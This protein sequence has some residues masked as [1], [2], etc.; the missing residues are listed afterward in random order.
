LEYLFL[1][2]LNNFPDNQESFS[3]VSNTVL[4]QKDRADRLREL[5]AQ[6]SEAELREDDTAVQLA[7]AEFQEIESQMVEEFHRMAY[8]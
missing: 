8:Y 2:F 1:T 5:Q 7:R 4:L 6:I 3:M